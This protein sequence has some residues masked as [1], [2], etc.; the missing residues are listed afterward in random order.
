M[1][2]EDLTPM[3]GSVKDGLESTTGKE[4]EQQNN[5]RPSSMQ[6]SEAEIKQDSPPLTNAES[7]AQS[8][9]A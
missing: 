6:A 9:E 4:T 1:S 2:G 8:S 3:E 5:S 7:Q